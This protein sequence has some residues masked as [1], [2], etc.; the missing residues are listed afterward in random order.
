MAKDSF[1]KIALINQK[2]RD[3]ALAEFLKLN[4]PKTAKII[5]VGCGSGSW[6]KVLR[7]LG[8]KNIYGTD[9]N[10][11]ELYVDKIKVPFKEANFNKPFPYKDKEFDVVFSLEVIEH[12]ENPWFF[13]EEIQRILKPNGYCIMTTPNPDMLASRIIFL[14]AGRFVHFGGG[15]LSYEQNRKEPLKDKH[16]TPVFHFLYREMVYK[17]FKILAYKGNGVH[18]LIAGHEAYIGIKSPLFGMNKIYVLQKT[19]PYFKM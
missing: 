14:L 3:V 1:H 18:P 15:S 19:F 6:L 7:D 2:S 10:A 11:E 13:M 8:Y 5:D 16:R 9:M 12:V 17:R 4:V